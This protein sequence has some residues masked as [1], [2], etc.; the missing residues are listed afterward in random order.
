MPVK[1]KA[2]V[3]RL[4]VIRGYHFGDSVY[5][6]KLD[7]VIEYRVTHSE[8]V[9][10][11]DTGWEIGVFDGV[12]VGLFLT[13]WA[14]KFGDRLSIADGLVSIDIAPEK[15]KSTGNPEAVLNLDPSPIDPIATSQ[16]AE[17]DEVSWHTA[18]AYSS[19]EAEGVACMQNFFDQG[20]AWIDRIAMR[21]NTAAVPV[22]ASATLVV[23]IDAD[24]TLCGVY[25]GR[26]AGLSFSFGTWSDATYAAIHNA[27]GWQDRTVVDA[28]HISWSITA[29]WVSQAIVDFGLMLDPDYLDSEPI[30]TQY[31]TY[32]D[33]W[34]EYTLPTYTGTGS[35]SATKA[36]ASASGTYVAAASGP[37]FG[38]RM[39]MGI[40]V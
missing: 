30:H 25:L 22:V 12:R 1:A 3:R 40:G 18:H 9:V 6:A 7:D 33:S 35:G 13:D 17:V 36:T 39:M 34:I 26:A 2:G 8:G 4:S 14:R 5:L 32:V 31:I 15:A 27:I 11:A 16:Y 38:S 37:P 29:L 28:T 10:R 21:F 19:G 23:Q 20:L 24:W